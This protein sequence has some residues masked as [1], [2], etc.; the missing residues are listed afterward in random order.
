MKFFSGKA[1]RERYLG[2]GGSGSIVL[3]ALIL[4]AWVSHEKVG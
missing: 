4:F 1:R 2:S 3:G